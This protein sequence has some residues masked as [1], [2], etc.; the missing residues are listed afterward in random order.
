MLLE[1]SRNA[2]NAKAAVQQN[3][4]ALQKKLSERQ[5][6]LSQLDQAKM[7]EQMNKAMSQ[8][9]ATVGEDVP[10]FAEV[11]AKIEQRLAR[12][13]GMAELTNT[14]VESSMLEVE[15]AQMNAEAQARLSE[16]RTQLGLSSPGAASAASPAAPEAA[17]TEGTTPPAG[18]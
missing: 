18:T 1:Q 17:S 16:L 9:S 12:A 15:Q 11:E 5:K 3:S 14:T 8:L 13:Q 2:D 7:Q 4:M 10:T 6:L